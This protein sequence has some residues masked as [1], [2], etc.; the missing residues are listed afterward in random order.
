MSFN[1][2]IQVHAGTIVEDDQLTLEQLCNTCAVDADWIVSLVDESI[3]EPDGNE[4]RSWRFSGISLR[5]V[6]TAQRLQK[7]LGVNLAGIALALDLL[8][9]LNQLREQLKSTG[10]YLNKQHAPS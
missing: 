6:R 5:R 9:E 2:T 3:I 4:I 8:E 7:D 1:E 10:S